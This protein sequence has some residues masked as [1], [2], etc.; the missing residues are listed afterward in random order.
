[1]FFTILFSSEDF[2]EKNETVKKLKFYYFKHNVLSEFAIN[3]GLKTKTPL[4]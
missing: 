2:I 1:L 3:D 4:P